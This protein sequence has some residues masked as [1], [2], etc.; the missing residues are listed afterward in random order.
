MLKPSL[1]RSPW[2]YLSGREG[3]GREGALGREEGEDRGAEE[4][5]GGLLGLETRGAWAKWGAGA[6][7]R[8]GVRESCP[9]ELERNGGEYTLRGTLEREGGS[10]DGSETPAAGDRWSSWLR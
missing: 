4:R 8:E 1:S 6:L 10:R 2:V 9:D 5:P 3:A 7:I